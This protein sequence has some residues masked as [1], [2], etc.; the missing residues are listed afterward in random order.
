MMLTLLFKQE[1]ASQIHAVTRFW[2]SCSQPL[3]LGAQGGL[4]HFGEILA[5]LCQ[6]A[7]S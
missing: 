6:V 3:F 7:I 4:G 5:S 2:Q 1:S